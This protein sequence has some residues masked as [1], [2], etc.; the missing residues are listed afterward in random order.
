[1]ADGRYLT[2][3]NRAEWNRLRTQVLRATPED[4]LRC[5]EWLERFSREGAV[6]VV[7][8]DEALQACE[9]LEI[10]DL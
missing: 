5:A 9:G 10:S 3:V 8:Y 1:M 4:L 2:G 6:C 7:G